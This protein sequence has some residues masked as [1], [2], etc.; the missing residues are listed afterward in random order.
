MPSVSFR[1]ICAIKNNLAPS[2]LEVLAFPNHNFKLVRDFLARDLQKADNGKEVG[3][4]NYISHS[5]KV[6]FKAKAF[7]SSSYL[8][9]LKNGIPEY[10]RPQVFTDYKLK[11]GDVLISKDS[12]IGEVVILDKDY[13]NA[14]PSGAIYKLPFEDN[15]YY[16]LA[17]MKSKIV[18]DQLDTM[19]PK[20]AT[21]RHAKTLFLDCK[22][23][24]PNQSNSREVMAYVEHLIR[25]I[26]SKEI[27]IQT[28]RTAIK[29]AIENELKSKND[30]TFTYN[31]TKLS[32]L[33]SEKRLDTG[34]YGENYQKISSMITHY[35]NGHKTLKELGY[36][37][38]RGQNLQV[39]NI[40]RSIYSNEP[41]SNFYKLVLSKDFTEWM[42]YKRNTYIGNAKKL[43]TI[44]KGDIIF[45]CRGDLGRV[46]V[47]CED[48]NGYITNIDNVHIRNTSASMSDNIFIGL[49]LLYLRDLGFL[50]NIAI[51]GSGADSF[52][53]YQF[54]YVHIPLFPTKIKEQ[55]A[56]EFHNPKP[57]PI[58]SGDGEQFIKEHEAW[59]EQVGVYELDKSI[60]SI[61]SHL[62]AVLND[63]TNNEPVDI[64][65]SF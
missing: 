11:K 14:M 17:F 60:K 52:T 35:A 48:N 65:F 8:L 2:Q 9:D 12:N 15:K 33:M 34:L 7:T 45:S 47:F 23:P 24:I 49:F 41:V 44:K 5:P 37:I 19:V 30:N 43:R 4:I 56:Q 61:Q 55:V 46:I 3:S 31:T 57:E 29:E 40:G 26:I 25:L 53:K 39:S 58:Y 10:I 54:D 32:D 63:I 13:P 36:S 6:F 59:D 62:D 28:K 51:T 20:G 18:K 16:A 38:V 50:S 1:D 42:T 27:A 21:I 22:I 64:N